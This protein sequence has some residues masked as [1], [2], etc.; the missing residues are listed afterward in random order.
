MHSISFQ[1]PHQGW[2][3]GLFVVKNVGAIW[4]YVVSQIIP[5]LLYTIA[6][7]CKHLSVAVG[8][9]LLIYSKHRPGIMI[10]CGLCNN[11]VGL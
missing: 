10:G 4:R 1:S 5:I 7:E 11:H 6:N 8:T 3:E 9:A 2:F